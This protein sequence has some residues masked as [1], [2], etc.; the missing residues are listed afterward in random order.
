MA[1]TDFQ[2][3]VAAKSEDELI[4]I[5]LRKDEFR[6]ELVE[7][8]E[9]ELKARRSN[10]PTE[11]AKDAAAP[12]KTIVREVVQELKTSSQETEPT[13]GVYLAAVISFIMFPIWIIIVMFQGALSSFTDNSFL[14][15]LAISNFFVT[16]VRLVVGIG[17]YKLKPWG[18]NW[19]LGSAMLNLALMGLL[20]A[21]VGFDLFIFM[22]IAEGVVA[23]A[24]YNNRALFTEPAAVLE[25]SEDKTEPTVGKKAIEDLSPEYLA[26]LNKLSELM[27]QEKERFMGKSLKGEI[28][29]KLNDLIKSKEDGERLLSDYRTVFGNDLTNALIDLTSNYDAMKEYLKPFIVFEIVEAQFPHEIKLSVKTEK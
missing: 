2:S 18:Y 1:R 15:I 11:S 26:N 3:I 20:Y 28:I 14:S 13:M 10:R 12:T 4:D 29:D 7:A 27:K 21:G 25:P 9:K 5:V 17:I 23:L 16:V 8:A 19:G 6:P 22:A 24:L